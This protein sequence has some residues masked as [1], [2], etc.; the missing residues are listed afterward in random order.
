MS[1]HNFISEGHN[2]SL[3]KISNEHAHLVDLLKALSCAVEQKPIGRD[4]ITA[5]LS[6]L[7]EVTSEHFAHEEEL[8]LES[9]YAKYLDHQKNHE[10]VLGLIKNLIAQHCEGDIEVEGKAKILIEKWMLMHFKQFDKDLVTLV[11]EKL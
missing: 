10:H 2:K 1:Q 3:K 8:M 11:S 7:L 4:K 9:G 6:N 5:A